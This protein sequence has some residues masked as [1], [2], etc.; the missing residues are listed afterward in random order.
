MGPDLENMSQTRAN[1]SSDPGCEPLSRSNA[2]NLLVVRISVS[3]SRSRRMSTAGPA[4]GEGAVLTT[5][6]RRSLYHHKL[7]DRRA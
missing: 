4:A 2:H 3:V 5:H 1:V 6:S 7:S